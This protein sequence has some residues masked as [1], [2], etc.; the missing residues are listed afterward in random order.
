[1]SRSQAWSRA[2]A[3]SDSD[4]DEVQVDHG[5]EKWRSEFARLKPLFVDNIEA[6]AP[7]YARCFPPSKDAGGVTPGHG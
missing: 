7:Y 5:P 3:A 6:L 1:V 4:A 2:L